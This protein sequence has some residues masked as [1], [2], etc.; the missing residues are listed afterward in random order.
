MKPHHA[1]PRAIAVRPPH[2]TLQ[3]CECR[4]GIRG[5]TGHCITCRRWAMVWQRLQERRRLWSGAQ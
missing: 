5:I 2:W 4:P 3:P 1:L